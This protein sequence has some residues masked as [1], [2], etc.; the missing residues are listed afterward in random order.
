LNKLGTS[1][2]VPF[3]S[4][5][6]RRLVLKRPS[7]KDKPSK[8]QALF[9]C[10]GLLSISIACFTNGF[11]ADLPNNHISDLHTIDATI[12]TAM[13]LMRVPGIAVT[14]VD[15]QGPLLVQGYG[16]RQV[17]ESEPVDVD[18]LFP[19]ASTSKA[20]TALA[21]ATLV[22]VKKLEWDDPLKNHLP[23]LE[24]NDPY[25]TEHVT[26][27]DALAHRVG[28]VRADPGWLANP[29]W[30]RAQL[31]S[32]LRYIP[33]L[34]GF[35]QGW[36]YSNWMYTAA[37]QV[38]PALTGKSWD[39]YLDEVIF[40]PLEMQNTGT[41]FNML[42]T[43]GNVTSGHVVVG[44]KIA[45]V[46]LRNIEVI[47]PA[48]SINSTAT[49]MGKWCEL[50]LGKGSVGEKN[51][52]SESIFTELLQPQAV[53]NAPPGAATM[54]GGFQHLA[55]TLGWGRMDYRSNE[56]MYWHNG[57]IDGIATQVALLPESGICI[58]I[59]ANRSRADALND[60]VR[61]T[62]LDL[63]LDQDGDKTD[64]FERAYESYQSQMEFEAENTDPPGDI[65]APDLDIDAFTGLFEH[66]IYGQATIIRTSEQQLKVT[67]G[68]ALQT[69]LIRHENG[70][71][72]TISE[73]SDERAPGQLSQFVVNDIG[74]I[75]G[76]KISFSDSGDDVVT[77]TRT[78]PK[79]ILN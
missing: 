61:N 34:D 31:L 79:V 48:G 5:I 63:L 52:V 69:T 56:T 12:N 76:F 67:F 17:G 14:V 64:W 15:K 51:I 13:Q 7:K 50:L 11:A 26:V 9:A 32:K 78:K 23:S 58:A 35:R 19:I 46:P 42:N 20:F 55:Y 68:T 62:I 49:D 4:D 40:E 59:L 8:S 57:G 72:E 29:G 33:S 74:R 2:G 47:G 24:F 30:S 41:R 36:H 25:L 65:V 10:I 44:G 54:G 27:R 70:N 43:A 6:Q 39:N 1:S 66:P 28:L 18:T 21:L 45:S 3:F 77:Y 71:F 53:V 38:I 60:A 16:L 22:D 75:T 73:Q 37:G